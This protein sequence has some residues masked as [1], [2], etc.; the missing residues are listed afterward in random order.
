MSDASL[1]L[2]NAALVEL[3]PERVMDANG[4]LPPAC[5]ENAGW[6]V[7]DKSGGL[8]PARITAQGEFAW[9]PEI[10]P[11]AD[12]AGFRSAALER[13][14][15]HTE[16]GT[17][18]PLD[19]LLSCLD[20]L[21]VDPA[22]YATRTGL[23]LLPEPSHLHFAGFDRYGRSLWLEPHTALAWTRMLAAA[24]NDGITLEAI[25]GFRSHRYQLGIFRRKLERGQTVAEILQVN[26][27]PGF[28]EHHTGLALDI[29]APGEPAAEE[30]FEGTPAFE[31]LTA[32]GATYG[33]TMSYPRDNPHGIVYEP[34]HWTRGHALRAAE[35]F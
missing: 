34:W 15:A 3:W 7:R 10:A 18:V 12:P 5:D 32:N 13:L 20:A 30:S 23:R 31:W 29:S 25:S 35:S 22:Q 33:F 24:A 26:A 4:L 2:L 27:A 14:T 9:C 11:P 16:L 21:Q 17:P 6:R 28:S 8:F 1:Q 19:D